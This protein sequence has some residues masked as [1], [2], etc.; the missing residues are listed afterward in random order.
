MVSK[1]PL[2]DA[3]RRKQHKVLGVKNP[4]LSLP[5][6]KEPGKPLL[7]IFRPFQFSRLVGLQ[8]AHRNFLSAC[9]TL[10]QVR[11]LLKPAVTQVN[12][13]GQQVNVANIEGTATRNEP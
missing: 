10:A 4:R 11:K 12:I 5:R 2:R 1:N 3:A 8:M 9:K 6:T 7:R 13:G